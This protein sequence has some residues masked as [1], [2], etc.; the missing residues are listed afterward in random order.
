MYF[1]LL[2]VVLGNCQKTENT[3]DLTEPDFDGLHGFVWPALS[4]W[5]QEVLL[6]FIFALHRYRDHDGEC[7]P[8]FN[9]RS[10]GRDGSRARTDSQVK[11]YPR[12]SMATRRAGWEKGSISHVWYAPIKAARPSHWFQQSVQQAK[13]C[14]FFATQLL[15]SSPYW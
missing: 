9:Q 11:I 4:Y 6:L 5:V 10:K 15:F 14:P 13:L 3:L 1:T 7:L 2:E 8:D 12:K